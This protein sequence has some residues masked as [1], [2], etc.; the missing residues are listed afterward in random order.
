MKKSLFLLIPIF[1]LV[2][3]ADCQTGQK[4][5]PVLKGPYLGQKPPEMI[6]EIFAPGFVST[7][8]E[9]SVITFMPDGRECY[10]S[11]LLSGFETILTSRLENGKWSEPEVALFSGQYYDGWPAIQPDGKRMFF[12]SSRPRPTG[13][14]GITAKYNIWY[15]DR[16]ENGWSEPKIVGAPVNGSENATCPSLTNNGTIYISKR[17]KDD[18]EKLCRS[19][20][21][22]GAYRELELLPA[23]VN[24]LQYNFHGA[25]SPDERFLVRPLYGGK[26][27][28]GD[29]WNY[30]ASFRSQ[31]GNWS[32]L[33]NLGKE[34]NSIMCAGASSFSTDGK[35]LFFQAMVPAKNILVLERKKS[36]PEMLEKEIRNPANGSADIY[37]IDAEI[38]EELRPKELK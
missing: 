6:P 21:F 23:H 33:I 29:G 10:W 19:E 9:E 24:S 35:Y 26:D 1:L 36:L 34:I 14:P 15:V 12:H 28:I 20:F 3:F 25:V 4:D 27:S 38:I 2:R 11:I 18:T 8:L 31:D 17:F 13:N 32:D 37:W 30:Y 7:G 22:N 16:I 5:S